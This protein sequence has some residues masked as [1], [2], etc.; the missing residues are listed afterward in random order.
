MAPAYIRIANYPKEMFRLVGQVKVLDV[1]QNNTRDFHDEGLFSTT[2]FGRVGSA[3]RIKRMGYIDFKVPVFHP[4]IFNH[5]CSLKALY[6]GI[7]SGKEYA[8]WDDRAKDFVKSD[9]MEGETGYYF[10]LKHWKDIRFTRTGSGQRDHRIKIIKNNLENALQE[11]LPVMP[12]GLRELEVDENGGIDQ[13]EIN[14][15]YRVLIRVSNTLSTINDLDSPIIDKARFALQLAYN[16]LHDYIMTNTIKGKGSFFPAKFGRRKLRYGTRNVWTACSVAVQHLDDPTNIGPDDTVVGLFQAMKATEPLMIH[17]LN[18]GYLNKIFRGDGSVWLL[19][20]KTLNRVECTLTPKSIDKWTT[21]AG[22]TKLINQFENPRLRNKPIKIEGKYLG[23][24]YK[25]NGRYKLM[26][27]MDEI[28]QDR[29]EDKSYVYPLTY[30]E[31]FFILISRYNRALPAD[32]TRYPIEGSGSMYPSY[33]Y[34]YTTT[35]PLRMIELD[36]AWV[37]TP[38]ITAHYPNTESNKWFD[39]MAPHPTHV[40]EAGGDYDGD[41]GNYNVSY[42]EES[43]EAV[44]GYLNSMQAHVNANGD[45]IGNPFT[46]IPI[47][48][49]YNLSGD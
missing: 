16:E 24:V 3:E 36:E 47:K 19:D 22:L 17:H 6:K 40:P 45:L 21:T 26:V 41:T 48:V 38:I 13:H 2:I 34:I 44:F 9:Q 37:D 29:Q 33:G 42:S 46:D 4:R 15:Y 43:K 7:M 31:L 25:R 27:S 23:L 30:G 5:L 11:R 28:P 20:P 49:I 32:I 14:D 8:Y 35:D 39:S 18:S 10:F 1:F 12:A